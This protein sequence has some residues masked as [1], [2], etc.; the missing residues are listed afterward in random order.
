MTASA[1][2]DGTSFAL[3]LESSRR[4]AVL[5]AAFIDW[6]GSGLLLA[7]AP[8]FL[9]RTVGLRAKELG[10]ALTTATVFGFVMSFPISH[11]ADRWSARRALV[12]LNVWR[13]LMFLAYAGHHKQL[14]KQ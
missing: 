11:L 12:A 9:V 1:R 5:T 14:M 13:G 8:V 4:S 3:A 2:L 10:V 7:C 6:A